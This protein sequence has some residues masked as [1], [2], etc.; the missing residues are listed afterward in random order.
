M[1]RLAALISAVL[2]LGPVTAWSERPSAAAMDVQA[3]GLK[4]PLVASLTQALR[5]AL[6]ADGGYR[7]VE[8]RASLVELRL[9]LD[10]A[11]GSPACWKAVAESL[12]AEV[13]FVAQ[14]RRAGPAFE[15]ELQRYDAT[16]AQIALAKA[17]LS[18]PPAAV[19]AR[20]REEAARFMHGVAVGSLAVTAVPGPAAVFV[21]GEPRGTTPVKLELPPGAY[22]VEVRQA[23][24]RPYRAQVSVVAGVLTELN[25]DLTPPPPPPAAPERGRLGVATWATWGVAVAALATGVALGVTELGTQ[26]D[27]NAIAPSTRAD[28]DRMRSL[29]DRGDRLALGADVALG[30]G[31]AAVIAAAILTY[32]DLRL[33]R[34]ERRPAAQQLTVGPGGVSLAWTY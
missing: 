14:V 3:E 2:A 26:S 7:V 30:V 24:L 18:G 5:A 4:P 28:V 11:N 13:L 23:G 27:Y 32:R 21:G 22:V 6:R 1:G 19:V 20:F 29:R 25:A 8:P 16:G 33:G 10:C 12:K 9:V 15:L 34:A 31:G 17:R